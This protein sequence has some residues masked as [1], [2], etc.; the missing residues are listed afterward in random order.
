MIEKTAAK[1]DRVSAKKV[2]VL[3]KSVI[4]AAVAAVVLCCIFIFAVI[5]AVTMQKTEKNINLFYSSQINGAVVVNSNVKANAIIDGKGVAGIKYSLTGEYAAV[6][7]SDGASYSLYYTDGKTKKQ[8]TSDASNNY[9]ISSDGTAVAFVNSLSELYLYNADT[10]NETCLDS[11]VDSFALSPSGEAMAYVKSEEGINVLYLY[12]EGKSNRI[13]E[14]YAPLGMSE[15]LSMIYVLSG[16]NSLYMLDKD[17]NMTA[18]ICSDVA[19]D[20]FYFSADMSDIVFSDGEYTYIS[21]EGKSKIRLVA[22]I[23]E[24]V[25]ERNL[26]VDS[27]G[28]GVVCENIYETFYYSTYEDS[29]AL[30]YIDK[31]LERTDIAANVQSYVITGKNSV[32]YLDSQYQIYKYASGAVSLIQSN[33]YNMTATSDGKYIY[34]TNSSS[35]LICIKNGKSTLVAENIRKIYMTGKNKLLYI[36]RNEELFGTSG[37]KTGKKIDDNVYACISSGSSAF[38]MKNY[39]AQTGV[40]ELYGSDGS[41]KF[42]LVAENVSNII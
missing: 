25:C 9:I 15:D 6:V 22:D 13:G 31:N 16:D 29:F 11:D 5:L 39:S 20:K 24:P 2:F 35:E 7:M 18:K 23:A 26:Y 17:G 28:T 19:T 41:V 30:Y 37:K 32:V 12:S 33:A 34:Y 36:N 1:T 42:R 21:S 10:D 3:K 14:D 8:L 4:A 40:F 38:Y 27:K